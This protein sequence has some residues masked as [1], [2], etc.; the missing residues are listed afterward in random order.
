MTTIGSKH[1]LVTGGAS[2]LGRGL[3][4]RCAALGATVSVLDI[5]E[6]GAQGGRCGGR[7]RAPAR[8]PATAATSATAAGSRG[9]RGGARWRPARSTSW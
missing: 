5:D 7:A 8:R 2:G 1:V 3:A 9:R 6:T 4:L